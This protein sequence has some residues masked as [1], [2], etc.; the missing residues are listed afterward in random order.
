MVLRR[1]NGRMRCIAYVTNYLATTPNKM[2]LC[3]YHVVFLH[4]RGT[5][6][7]P[8]LRTSCVFSHTTSICPSRR[9]F[10][11]T[12]HR[13]N[14]IFILIT[15]WHRYREDIDYVLFLF[16]CFVIIRQLPVIGIFTHA[17]HSSTVNTIIRLYKM[18]LISKKGY[19]CYSM[20]VYQYKCQRLV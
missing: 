9:D 3:A 16:C 6:L 1:C 8:L 14:Y 7:R 18:Y 2:V 13:R 10:T 11:C 12:M 15:K 5:H 17:S 4:S 19:R 20:S